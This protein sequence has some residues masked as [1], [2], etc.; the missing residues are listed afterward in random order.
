MAWRPCPWLKKIRRTQHTILGFKFPKQLTVLGIQ[1]VDKTVGRTEVHLAIRTRG[2]DSTMSSVLN[3]QICLPVLKSSAY[4]LP[5]SQPT[6]TLPSAIAAVPWMPSSALN[7]QS[8]LSDELSLLFE[9]PVSEAVPR[10]IGQ[11]SAGAAG[12]SAA[13]LSAWPSAKSR[14]KEASM[15]RFMTSKGQPKSP[16]PEIVPK[17]GN[18]GN[19]N[20]T[21][22]LLFLTH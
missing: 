18:Q 12:I 5:S 8:C 20:T 9:R 2:A 3:D 15:N 11:L 16:L 17:P 4:S 7:A 14:E 13:W 10:Y 6:N 21:Y 22:T 19:K 1:R